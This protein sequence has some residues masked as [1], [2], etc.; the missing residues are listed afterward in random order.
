MW[1]V[2]CR[3]GGEGISSYG[4]LTAFGYLVGTLWLYSRR[5]EVDGSDAEFWA[6]VFTLLL[7]AVLGAKLGYTLLDWDA[8]SADP[9]EALAY[10]RMGWVFW[11]GLAAAFLGGWVFQQVYNRLYRPRRYLPVADY[12]TTALALGHVFGRIGCFLEGCCY[13]RPTGLPWGVRFA[14]P[15]C[16]VDAALI[17]IPL[18]PTQLYEA[19]GEAALFFFFAHRVMPRIREG[20]WRC[21]T[22]FFGYILLYSILRFVIECFRADPRGAFLLGLSPSQWFSLAGMLAAALALYRNGIIERDPNRSLYL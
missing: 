4:V 20:S 15:A 14:H 10:W 17:G 16:A 5:K 12:F 9:R 2:L 13:G 21:G 3:I 7:S 6:L 22:A 11:P 1:P 8:A 19:A 18:H